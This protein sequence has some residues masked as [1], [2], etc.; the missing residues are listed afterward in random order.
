VKVAADVRRCRPAIPSFM[1]DAVVGQAADGVPTCHG[2]VPATKVA[3]AL[4]LVI[5][6]G[7][8]CN[9]YEGIFGQRSDLPRARV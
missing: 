8:M 9:R 3:D 6:S 2:Q 1:A 4:T 5:T 7:K